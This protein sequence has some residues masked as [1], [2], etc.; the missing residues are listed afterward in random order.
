MTSPPGGSFSIAWWNGS[1]D[2]VKPVKSTQ[3]GMA[4][5]S[6]L[7]APGVVGVGGGDI[8]RGFFSTASSEPRYHCLRSGFSSPAWSNA[9]SWVGSADG[10]MPVDM[11]D[12]SGEEKEKEQEE[13]EEEEEAGATAVRAAQPVSSDGDGGPGRP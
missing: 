4:G 12:A 8:A 6:G 7:I 13:E 11:S 9:G 2:P 3:V 1:S 5:G 10:V